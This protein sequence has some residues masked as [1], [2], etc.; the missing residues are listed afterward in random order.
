[1]RREAELALALK[2]GQPLSVC[3]VTLGITE[4]TAR[5]YLKSIFLKTGVQRQAE[6]VKL[7]LLT[8]R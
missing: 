5:Q 6:L 8:L 3:A 7:L 2:R 1:M 4:G